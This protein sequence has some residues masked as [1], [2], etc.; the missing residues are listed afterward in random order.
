M[1]DEVESKQS[2]STTRKS[3]VVAGVSPGVAALVVDLVV[4]L[5]P[6][7]HPEPDCN[8]YW[9]W[10]CEKHRSLLKLHDISTAVTDV[11]ATVSVTGVVAEAGAA[12]R[13]SPTVRKATMRRAILGMLGGRPVRRGAF[14]QGTTPHNPLQPHSDDALFRRGFHTPGAA[15][16]GFE[17]PMSRSRLL[18]LLFASALVA[19]T[20]LAA[21]QPAMA[22]RVTATPDWSA[23]Y[24]GGPWTFAMRVTNT[25]NTSMRVT[26]FSVWTNWGDPPTQAQPQHTS[27]SLPIEIPMGAQVRFTFTFN[28]PA[29]AASGRFHLDASLSAG[30][31]NATGGWTPSAAG[32]FPGWNFTVLSEPPAPAGGSSGLSLPLGPATPLILL[33]VAAGVGGV[34]IAALVVRKRR[35]LAATRVLPAKQP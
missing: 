7:T 26:A 3:Y 4:M 17:N 22:W 1:L 24:P 6:T 31:P 23:P 11:P 13:S 28:V 2:K 15:V 27:T 10:Y 12:I 33:A 5:A 18:P 16:S 29:S 25:G 20:L 21:S 14:A 9:T 34:S 32:A 8:R 19:G 30:A 35:R